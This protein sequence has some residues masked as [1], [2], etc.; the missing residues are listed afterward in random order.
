MACKALLLIFVLTFLL[1]IGIEGRIVRVSKSKDGDS[2]DLLQRL[3]YNVSEL[4]RL[5]EISTRNGI[6]R[7]SPGGPDPQHHSYHLSSKP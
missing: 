4:K 2:D 6:N 1:V 3:G 5:G 7:F